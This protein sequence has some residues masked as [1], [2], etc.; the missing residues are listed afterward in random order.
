M[1]ILN[2]IDRTVARA[3]RVSDGTRLDGLKSIGIDTPDIDLL[4][5]SSSYAS[6]HNTNAF[7]VDSI[8]VGGASFSAIKMQDAVAFI[9][10]LIQKGTTPHH[11]VTGNLD[12]LYRLETD[13]EFQQVYR[14]AS[15]V[16]PDGMPV[17]WLSRLFRLAGEQG[18]PERVA[19]SDLLIELARHSSISGIRL[20]LLGGEPGAADG[21][22]AVLENRFPGCV[23]CGTYCP[24]RHLFHTAEE[25]DQIRKIVRAANPDILLVAFGAPKQ[26]KWILR[27]KALLGVPVLMGVGGSFEMASGM[28]ARAPKLIQM[29]GME[30]AFRMLQDPGR[31]WR[32][33]IGNN[34]PF[35]FRL[36]VRTAKERRASTDRLV[37]RGERL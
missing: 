30:W 16:L 21:T 35:L 24:P 34:L 4:E 22:R 28:V 10:L 33:Y 23:I 5:R 2:T 8:K 15:L 6:R 18:L 3:Q 26:E 31:L 9:T 25:Q 12:H 17:V 11:V 13:E 7:D 37:S 29:L 1:S 14:S 27:N 20:F 36:L 19:G 32:R